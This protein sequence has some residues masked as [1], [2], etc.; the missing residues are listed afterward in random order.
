M[1]PLSDPN[2]DLKRLTTEELKGEF[3]K[4]KRQKRAAPRAVAKA[5]DLYVSRKTNGV[6]RLRRADKVLNE[7]AK[8]S[9]FS[10]RCLGL[11]FYGNARIRHGFV[12]LHGLGAAIGPCV[13][14]ALLMK[15]RHGDKIDW[16]IETSTV[17][18]VDDLICEVRGI[19]SVDTIV[20]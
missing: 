5:T 1:R 9:S 12:H 19:A 2:E 20:P 13:D 4:V 7:Y 6:A 15:Y 16:T 11:I 17:S 8:F 18:L 3:K 14:L 10:W